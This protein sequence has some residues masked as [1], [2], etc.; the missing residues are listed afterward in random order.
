MLKKL[1]DKTKL[2]LPMALLGGSLLFSAY[3]HS[4]KSIWVNRYIDSLMTE[5]QKHL[6]SN[7][8]KGLKIADGLEVSTFA[9]EPMLLNPTDI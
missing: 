3:H 1:S 6:P 4:S 2:G 7:A 8:L 5:E 9:T